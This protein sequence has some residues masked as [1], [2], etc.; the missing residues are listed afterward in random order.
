LP[1][2]LDAATFIPSRAIAVPVLQT[3]P[4]VVT[5]IGST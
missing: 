5:R 3:I 2:K 4:P 1:T